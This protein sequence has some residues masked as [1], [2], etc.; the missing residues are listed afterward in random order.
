LT[1]CRYAKLF[2]KPHRGI[3]RVTV[4]P[5][6]IWPEVL[7]HPPPTPTLRRMRYWLFNRLLI[8]RGVIFNH[9]LSF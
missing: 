5:K 9:Q 4:V 3:K 7:F 1:T 6:C 2:W 8:P